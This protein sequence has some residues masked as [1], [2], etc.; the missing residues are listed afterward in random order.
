LNINP[1]NIFVHSKYTGDQASGYDIALI[2]IEKN[3]YGKIEQYIYNNQER[4][5]EN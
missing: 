3:D 2:V 4:L 1:K 5:N